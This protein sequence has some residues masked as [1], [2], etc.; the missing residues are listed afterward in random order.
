MS[1]H[2]SSESKEWNEII[3]KT[4]THNRI[5]A[6]QNVTRKII[7]D[8][9]AETKTQN[10]YFELGLS[11]VSSYADTHTRIDCTL[12]HNMYAFLRCPV[13]SRFGT[14]FTF[15]ARAR[16]PPALR[17]TWVLLVNE[18]QLHVVLESEQDDT[19]T[20][21]VLSC[22]RMHAHRTRTW[23]KLEEMNFGCRQTGA[24]SEWMVA[25]GAL[26]DP[27]HRF[28]FRYFILFFYARW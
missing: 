19:R 14:T 10:Q 27:Q 28:R 15:W 6:R 3:G 20:S 25:M 16:R 18:D 2:K 11:C 12:F 21:F 4:R 7:D 9:A 13:I 17:C 23:S 1:Q 8:G 26:S 5:W 24:D 22:C